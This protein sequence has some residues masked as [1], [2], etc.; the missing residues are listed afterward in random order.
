MDPLTSLMN[1]TS[2]NYY[3]YFAI[4]Y[5]FGICTQDCHPDNVTLLSY[6]GIKVFKIPMK[7]YEVHVRLI[8]TEGNSICLLFVYCSLP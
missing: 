3:K 2:Y 8:S 5:N 6:F 4:N 1:M 7:A